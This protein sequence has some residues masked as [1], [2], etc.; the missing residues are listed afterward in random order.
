[1]EELV[2]AGLVKAIGVSNFNKDQMEA[3]LNKPGLKHKPATNQVQIWY[4]W[5]SLGEK[6]TPCDPADVSTDRVPP[7]PDPGEADW[8]LPLQR[9]LCDRLRPAG[10]PRE[11]LVRGV[12]TGGVCSV[13]MLN[14][15]RCS[16]LTTGLRRRN[17]LCWKSQRSK[18]L[19]KS[20]TRPQRRQE[21]TRKN[22]KQREQQ[23]A[24]WRGKKNKSIKFF[25]PRQI[26]IRF[27]I[28]RN[29]IVIAKSATPHR[30][31]ENFQVWLTAE[32][33]NVGHFETS[34]VSIV[35]T[36][37]TRPAFTPFKGGFGSLDAHWPACCD[38]GM[39]R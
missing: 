32:R 5:R 33:F 16:T 31:K 20:T 22:E 28:Q 13:S 24:F 18:P 23:G 11:T 6:Q 38:V 25:L 3:V 2:D 19:P 37:M 1:M 36:W 7:V 15:R 39:S 26:L 10:L 34:L 9:H 29:V 4:S 8:V 21:R 30:I 27:H 17:L 12:W 14:V 35:F